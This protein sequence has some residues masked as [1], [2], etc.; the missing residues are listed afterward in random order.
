LFGLYSLEPERSV[1]TRI[2]VNSGSFWFCHRS[3][4]GL[5]VITSSR[6]NVA[7]RWELPNKRMQQTAHVF[8]RKVVAL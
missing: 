3:N 8:K 7:S 2:E 4:I 1:Q 5:N 6:Y